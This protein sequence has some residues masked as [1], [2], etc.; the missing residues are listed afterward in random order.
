[1]YVTVKHDTMVIIII[2]VLIGAI[3]FKSNQSAA[4]LNALK[5]AANERYS[6]C[7]SSPYY[8]N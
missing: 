4:G 7:K 8:F 1:M 2:I 3:A 6:V 5:P